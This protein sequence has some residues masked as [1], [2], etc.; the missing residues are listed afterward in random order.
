MK[1][2]FPT[3]GK[4]TIENGKVKNIKLHISTFEVS[5]NSNDLNVS[6]YVTNYAN[7]TD[8]YDIP[9]DSLSAR[10]SNA[11]PITAKLEKDVTYHI[12]GH[13]KVVVL[14]KTDGKTTD[15][16]LHCSATWKDHYAAFGR[17]Q[18]IG[19][20]TYEW[21]IDKNLKSAVTSNSARVML[22]DSS[23]VRGNVTITDLKV[24]RVD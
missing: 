21:N 14:E 8:A 1:G 7:Q 12:T 2:E 22:V 24:E 23:Y 17:K 15:Y 20:K 3:G 16:M 18:T 11:I 6:T 5:G 19:V 9:F 4:V 13:V 10:T